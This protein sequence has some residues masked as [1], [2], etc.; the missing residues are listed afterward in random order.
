MAEVAMSNGSASSIVELSRSK[1]RYHDQDALLKGFVGCDG[2][3]A[4][5]VAVE[6]LDWRYEQYANCPKRAFDL[7]RLGYLEQLQG[8]VCRHTN[9]EAHTYR[10][11]EKGLVHLRE[12]GMA[13]APRPVDQ[14][15]V[16]AIDQSAR[17]SALRGLL[18]PS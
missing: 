16:S 1:S 14:P 7:H 8:K 3:T 13:V 15:T 6:V 10:I 4:K 18:G 2:W 5:E 9:K 12:I 11:T 17:L